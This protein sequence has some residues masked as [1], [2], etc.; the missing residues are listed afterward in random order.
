MWMTGADPWYTYTRRATSLRSPRS[1]LLNRG[2]Q[3]GLL[4]VSTVLRPLRAQ[5]KPSLYVV[6]DAVP[7]R[8]NS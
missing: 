5:V 6:V 3:R 2:R 1:R 4:V 7:E 8:K